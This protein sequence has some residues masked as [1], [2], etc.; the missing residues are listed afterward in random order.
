MSHLFTLLCLGLIAFDAQAACSKGDRQQMRYGGMEEARVE[1]LC[2]SQGKS[3]PRKSPTLTTGKI[4]Q[5]EDMRCSLPELGKLNDT[6]WC[7]SS[8]GAISGIVMR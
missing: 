7:S 5:A 1:A 8:A 4:C 2:G 6:C 3:I